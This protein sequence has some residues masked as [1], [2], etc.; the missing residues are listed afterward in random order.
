MYLLISIILT[1]VFI[2]F[3]IVGLILYLFLRSSHS[4]E[5]E[6]S[7]IMKLTKSLSNIAGLQLYIEYINQSNDTI[8]RLDDYLFDTFIQ[9]VK[10][11]TT[12][13][14]FIPANS[15]YKI[16]IISNT[17]PHLEIHAIKLDYSNIDKLLEGKYMLKNHHFVNADDSTIST[18]DG[19]HLNAPCDI[20]VSLS[21]EFLVNN[22]K[23][24]DNCFVKQN[25]S[26][27]LQFNTQSYKYFETN[28]L[29]NLYFEAVK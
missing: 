20:I 13:A 24:Q 9:D 3:C 27:T 26:F 2:I 16:Y 11:N 17:I 5:I 28:I 1:S 23:H 10:I 6:S 25:T 19:F 12:S 4:L 8:I 21:G 18:V 15:N 7:S 14:C 29:P 22:V